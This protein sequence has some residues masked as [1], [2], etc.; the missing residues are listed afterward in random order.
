MPIPREKG[1]AAKR[2]KELRKLQ[3]TSA[4]EIE[5]IRGDLRQARIHS[6]EHAN[7]NPNGLEDMKNALAD[8]VENGL[9]PDALRL[10]GNMVE[11]IDAIMDR[12][13]SQSHAIGLLL[14]AADLVD[15]FDTELATEIRAKAN[16]IAGGNASE[17]DRWR[18]ISTPLRDI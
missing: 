16:A 5:V 18:E 12:P 3:R 1:R 17:R 4:Q 8:A 6:V 14:N 2:A 13:P 9:A 7:G 11:K 10:G 15:N